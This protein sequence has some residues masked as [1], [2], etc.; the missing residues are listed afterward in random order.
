MYSELDAALAAIDDA[1]KRIDHNFNQVIEV[2]DIVERNATIG[3][4][5]EDGKALKKL[6]IDVELENLGHQ[7]VHLGNEA[8]LT[9]SGKTGL[10]GLAIGALL[11]VI[12]FVIKK[13]WNWFKGNGSSDSGSGSKSNKDLE[14]SAPSMASEPSNLVKV[15]EILIDQDHVSEFMND[16]SKFIDYCNGA[17]GDAAMDEASEANAAKVVSKYADALSKELKALGYKPKGSTLVELKE[18]V[19]NT[20]PADLPY[21]NIKSVEV[22]INSAKY[23]LEKGLEAKFDKIQKDL[24]SLEKKEVKSKQNLILTKSLSAVMTQVMSKTFVK[25][26]A[27]IKHHNTYLD[28]VTALYLKAF[29][30]AALT[31]MAK[32]KELA[33]YFKSVD[34]ASSE[35]IERA[36]A[37]IVKDGKGKGY[38]NLIQFNKI[39]EATKNYEA[40][41]EK[42]V[43]G[44]SSKKKDD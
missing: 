27:V 44:G 9:D 43:D 15:P 6:G 11:V 40:A 41:V 34:F 25:I 4:N 19:A 1:G 26:M 28:S 3:L 29:D 5:L 12:G 35:S 23:P 36:F 38:P 18:D 33:P 10:Y 13:V 22:F 31:K 39:A 14:K 21:G 30:G 37:K 24:S 20:D 42:I 16:M 17:I 32:D 7:R 8:M 2:M